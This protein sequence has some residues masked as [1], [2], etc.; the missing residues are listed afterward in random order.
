MISEEGKAPEF[1]L[2]V[3]SPDSWDRDRLEKPSIYDCMS[4]REYVLFY[5]RQKGRGPWL[6]G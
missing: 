2:E 3:A 1:A 6:V 5:P 4:V